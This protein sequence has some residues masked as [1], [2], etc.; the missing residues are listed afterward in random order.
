M[1]TMEQQHVYD[2]YSKIATHFDHTRF[3]HWKCVADFLDDLP[4][5]SIVA[6]IGTGNGKYLTYRNDVTIIGNDTCN[7]LLQIITNKNKYTNVLQANGLN[8][9]YKDHAFDAVISVAVMHHLS[10]SSSRVEFLQEAIRILRPGGRCII[11]VW[12]REQPIKST[13]EPI[14]NAND[15]FVPWTHKHK[16]YKRYYHLFTRHEIEELVAAQGDRIRQYNVR[17]ELG[18]WCL[19]IEAA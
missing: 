6:D 13:W 3:S 4:K 5:Y 17:Y 15:F 11:T 12:A 10:T 19:G 9:P 18:N 1:T 7:E 2:V 8:L 16:M 14:N